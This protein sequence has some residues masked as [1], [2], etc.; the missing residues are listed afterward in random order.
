MNL[1]KMDLKSLKSKPT[2]MWSLVAVLIFAGI[3][4]LFYAFSGG[5]GDAAA[6]ADSD[7]NIIYTNAAATVNAQQMT[8]QAA[9]TATPNLAL[10]T[11]SATFAPLITT[12][13]QP[14]SLITPTRPAPT[15]GC[16][17]SIYVSDVTVPDGTAMTAGQTFTKTWKVSNTGACTWTAT[18]KLV[19]V[20]GEGMGGASTPIGKE[21]KPGES[22]DISV[23]LTAPSKSGELKGTWRLSND[24]SAAFGDSLTVVIKIGTVPTPTK[25]P[26]GYP[27]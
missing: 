23:N 6:T 15:S 8:L 4:T 24:K 18:Y 13:G 9:V 17:M 12:T 20:A 5:K 10:L 1:K 3:C 11:P 14:L 2:V 26:G 22:V 21:V 25:T 19:F 7:I 27:N 16:D